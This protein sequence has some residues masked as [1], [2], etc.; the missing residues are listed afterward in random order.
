MI[1]MPKILV[2]KR[3]IDGQKM[4]RSLDK[5]TFCQRHPEAIVH[6]GRPDR[7]HRMISKGVR[8]TN[9]LSC[10]LD[11]LIKFGE[12]LLTIIRGSFRR[13][14][15]TQAYRKP[16]D[17]GNLS[18]YC[19]EI[20]STNRNG[21]SKP[22]CQHHFADTSDHLRPPANRLS[23]PFADFALKGDFLTNLVSGQWSS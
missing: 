10:Q 21:I 19:S 13:M 14:F 4:R 9:S 7:L 6:T 23:R 12:W 2:D 20:Y 1:R 15:S 11:S 8:M 18:H 17:D 16:I 5:G 22:I 3:L